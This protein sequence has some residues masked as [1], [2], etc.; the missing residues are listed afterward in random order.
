MRL[1]E[2][3]LLQRKCNKCEEEE[4]KH[5]QRK[6]ISENISPVIQTKGNADATVSPS[7]S[8]KINSTQGNGS[9]LDAN[10]QSFMSG[11]FGVDFRSVKIHVG[12]DAIQMNRELNAK[13][14]TVGNDI[15]FN[16][17]E[18]KPESEGGRH[19]LAHELVHTLQQGNNTRQKIMRKLDCDLAHIDNECNS[20]ASKCKS[21]ERYCAKN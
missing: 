11:R 13:A 16:S 10:I 6:S 15:Y 5:I 21:V 19:L 18:Y 1:P 9:S 17:G 20:A 8:N 2:S 3:P 7:L 12:N 4:E 14:F